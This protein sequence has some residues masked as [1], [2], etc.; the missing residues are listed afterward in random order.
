[1]L[2]QRLRRWTNIKLTLGQY[3]VFAVISKKQVQHHLHQQK[4]RIYNSRVTVSTAAL[5]EREAVQQ[6]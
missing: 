3:I 6:Q 2:V 5:I 4:Q 1:M